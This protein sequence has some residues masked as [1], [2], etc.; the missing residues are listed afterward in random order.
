MHRATRDGA[1]DTSSRPGSRESV[2]ATLRPCHRPVP[3]LLQRNCNVTPLPQEQQAATG[4]E[5]TDRTVGRE[6]GKEGLTQQGR[7][8]RVWAL[9]DVTVFTRE[10]ETGL[11]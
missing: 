1:P 4:H 8:C 11:V 7:P 10:H 3:G 2:V 9:S 5:P 6:Q